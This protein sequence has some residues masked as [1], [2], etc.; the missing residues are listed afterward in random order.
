MTFLFWFIL[1]IGLI[2]GGLS[3]LI[4]LILSLIF[5]LKRI[6]LYRL[7]PVI[8]FEHNTSD[9]EDQHLVPQ[10]HYPYQDVGTYG[11]MGP[12]INDRGPPPT[13]IR[14]NIRPLVL[15]HRNAGPPI[16]FIH[17]YQPTGYEKLKGGVRKFFSYSK[18]SS[19][20]DSV[21]TKTGTTKISDKSEADQLQSTLCIVCMTTPI[22][23]MLSPCCHTEM[24]YGCA[25]KIRECCTCRATIED[26]T[27]LF[28]PFN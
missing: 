12:P 17:P 14:R 2:G 3:L 23:T 25:D 16:S 20:K 5:I 7:P 9:S 22:N 18:S 6:Y 11:S 4:L 27:K 13:Q 26:R 10:P 24:C 8:I 21:S 15:A 19:S 28:M 1:K